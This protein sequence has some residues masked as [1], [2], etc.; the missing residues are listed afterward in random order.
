VTRCCEISETITFSRTLLHGVYVSISD[1][2]G[3]EIIL[4]LKN[5]LYVHI[6]HY[7][8]FCVYMHSCI[9]VYV[10]VLFVCVHLTLSINYE[11]NI[12]CL[13][14]LTICTDP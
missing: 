10:C 4:A 3:V 9:Y 1:I 11:K 2:Q 6:Q 7:I 8:A 13:I 5:S 12:R 14:P